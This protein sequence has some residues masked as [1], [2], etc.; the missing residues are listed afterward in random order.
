MED[1][2]D[3]ETGAVDIEALVERFQ[4]STKK[5]RRLASVPLLLPGWKEREDNPGIM[6]DLYGAIQVRNKPVKVS[7]HQ[8][9]NT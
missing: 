1:V 2:R 6:I 9:K 4:N 3:S 5:R 8:E 7:V